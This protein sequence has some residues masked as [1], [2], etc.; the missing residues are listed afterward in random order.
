MSTPAKRLT[1][2]RFAGVPELEETF[3]D[4]T[5]MKDIWDGGG[6]EPQS[7]GP[8]VVLLQES[9]LAMGY[10]LPKFG[11]DGIYGSETTAT[12]RQFQ[13]DAGHP[14]A[15]GSEW[16]HALGIGGANTLAHF[17]MFDPGGTIGHAQREPTGVPAQA[18]SFSESPHNPFAG[19]DATESPPALVLGTRTRRRVRVEC[20]PAVADVTYVVETPEVATV[21]LTDE[22][23]VI[24]GDQAGIT[25]V[26]ATSE[27]NVLAE[28]VVCV[29]D[30]R[31]E[32]VNFVFV[33]DTGEQQFATQRE[34]DK[35]ALL[36][37]RL[38]RVWRRQA[39]VHFT[40]GTVADVVLPAAVGPAL[41][42]EHLEQLS[43]YA[44]RGD[45]NVFCL[46]AIEPSVDPVQL[47]DTS[48]GGFM[49]LLPDA[50]CPDGMDV[51]SAAGRYLG[52]SGPVSGVMSGC[53]AGVDRRR[54]PKVVADA[55]NP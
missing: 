55:V 14:L 7:S 44:T 51:P 46:W 2:A 43:P 52:Y 45:L 31:E 18:A 30:V 48:G 27:G 1:A 15:P 40:L 20:E 54:V 8:H 10:E 17:E 12:V 37:L 13:V 25:V 21:A 24:A 49:L 34:H 47:P 39:N 33:S 3:S 16:E 32:V 53:G 19:F 36:T 5:G 26:R 38:N 35:A 42:A 41:R 28:L 22:G 29:K 9:L 11:A 23:I 4:T 6:R 50:G